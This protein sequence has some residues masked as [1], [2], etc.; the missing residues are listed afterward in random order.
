M[1][2][3][4]GKRRRR[5]VLPVS[6][7]LLGVAAVGCRPEPP[8]PPDPDEPTPAL[9]CNQVPLTLTRVAADSL[10]DAP[11]WSQVCTACPL[12]SGDVGFGDGAGGLL[13]TLSVWSPERECVVS[14]PTEPLP[15]RPSVPRDIELVDD[16]GRT[17]L[18]T[19]DVDVADGRGA[20]PVDLGTATWS[21]PLT[22]DGWRLLGG[23]RVLAD[24]PAGL[25][26]SLGPADA[27]AQRPATLG[28]ARGSSPVQ[29]TCEPTV[30]LGLATLLSRQVTVPLSAGDAIFDGLIVD[31]GALQARLADDASAL[32]DVTLL[33]VVSLTQS[34]P[35]LGAAP[36]VLCA[37]L[38]ADLGFSPC[39]PCGDPSLGVEGL[40]ACLPL[41]IEV[42]V[43]T[44]TDSPLI[45]VDAAA[46]DPGCRQTPASSASE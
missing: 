9:E 40:P 16:L 41:V 11:P 18:F 25:L 35:A 46:I 31:R 33:A 22:D 30:D 28:A 27:Q 5:L 26:L 13:D 19:D 3:P 2:D 7:L 44:R 21:L 45:P 10:L 1:A 24:P 38:E 6:A 12:A 42:P 29:D 23:S 8:G 4:S 20:D 17:A 37:E 34:E 43:A 32:F 39:V 15:A 14:I 36:D